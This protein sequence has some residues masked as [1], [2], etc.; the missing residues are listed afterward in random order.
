M[1]DRSRTALAAILS[2]LFVALITAMATLA[3]VTR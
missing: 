2:F 3:T 1:T